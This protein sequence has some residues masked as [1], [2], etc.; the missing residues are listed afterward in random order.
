LPA[1][2]SVTPIS[3]DPSERTPTLLRWEPGATSTGQPGR[4]RPPASNAATR[5]FPSAPGIHAYAVPSASI[6]GRPPWLLSATATGHPSSDCVGVGAA[7]AVEFGDACDA[8]G[9]GVVP[10]VAVSASA[11]GAT[12][13]GA[14]EDVD[15]LG[16]GCVVGE[17]SPQVETASDAATASASV[18]HPPD[19]PGRR[20]TCPSVGS[21]AVPCLA[22]CRPAPRA[23]PVDDSPPAPRRQCRPS[24]PALPSRSPSCPAFSDRG[25]PSALAGRPA[26]EDARLASPEPAASGAAVRARGARGTVFAS[27]HP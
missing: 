25:G 6:A 20:V 17:A 16:D 13:A 27:A 24:R 4:I 22:R 12:D 11:V 10:G 26:P 15:A 18:N 21:A 19:R 23:G 5:E 9:S 3:T 7:E 14:G 1:T 2:V 8:V